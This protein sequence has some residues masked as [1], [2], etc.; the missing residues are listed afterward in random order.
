MAAITVE[1]VRIFIK[2]YAGLNQLKGETEFSAPQI[3]R[4]I[5]FTINDFNSTPPPIRPISKNNIPYLELLLLGVV[6]HLYTGVAFHEKRNQLPVT[7]GGIS[8]D[9]SSR[10]AS[11]TQLAANLLSV[12]DRK[13]KEIKISRNMSQGWGV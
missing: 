6:G 4:A 1:D 10:A 13:K 8:I 11:Y 3:E 12:Y 2:D 7:T 5:D 9:D